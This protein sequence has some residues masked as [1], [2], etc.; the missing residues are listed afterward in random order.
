MELEELPP[1]HLSNLR[2]TNPQ[3]IR[4]RV[5]E[6]LASAPNVLLSILYFLK[7]SFIG[8]NSSETRKLHPTAYLDG[9][10]G[11]AAL[12]VVIA[13]YQATFFPYL[14]EG[15]HQKG[16]WEDGTEKKNNYI[17][18]LPMIRTFYASRFMVSIFFVISGYV[19]SQKPLGMFSNYFLY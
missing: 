13:H 3:R 18:Q 2:N 19:L 12:C 17:V 6:T 1:R 15:W 16:Q 14:G 10:R 9:L 8:H 7:P 4:S 11:V 5:T